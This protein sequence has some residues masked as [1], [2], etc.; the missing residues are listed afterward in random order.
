MLMS[1]CKYSSM[2]K[3]Y[4]FVFIKYRVR[5]YW[6]NFAFERRL[7]FTINTSKEFY[8]KQT[9]SYMVMKAKRLYS[10]VNEQ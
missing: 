1:T 4:I 6:P 2:D 8:V 5:I 9:Y 3:F 7:S 10:L